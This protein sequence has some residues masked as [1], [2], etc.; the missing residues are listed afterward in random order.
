MNQKMTKNTS[1]FELGASGR[2]REKTFS[3]DS[4]ENSFNYQFTKKSVT[5]MNFFDAKLVEYSGKYFVEL[6]KAKVE[7]SVEKER[8][9]ALN[10]IK[11]QDILLGVL[12]EHIEL[13]DYG[14]VAK[15]DHIEVH[16]FYQLMHIMVGDHDVIIAI[17][18]T[19]TFYNNYKPGNIVKFSFNGS[20]VHV[21]DKKTGNALDI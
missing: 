2:N 11:S 8:H 12:P 20:L 10:N 19:E 15:I 7:L 16:E 5:Q 4:A 18:N 6:G 13:R 1:R 14:V 3:F 9:L 17:P 21:F